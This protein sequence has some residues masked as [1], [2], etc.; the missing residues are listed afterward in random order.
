MNSLLSLGLAVFSSFFP[1]T[2]YQNQD[3]STTYSCGDLVWT[4]PAGVGDNGE[5]TG[6][7]SVTCNLQALSGGGFPELENFELAQ[8]KKQ[9]TQIHS[10]PTAG[11]DQGLPSQTYDFDM[12]LTFSGTEVDAHELET[13]AT[14]EKTHLVSQ[15]NTESITGSSYDQYLKEFNLTLDVKPTAAQTG[16]YTAVVSVSIDM[17]KPWFAPSSI[18]QTDVV[19][20]VQSTVTSQQATIVTEL[21]NNL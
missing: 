18:F 3:L 16:Y 9:A 12:N 1:Q 8:I 7:A 20:A 5:L 21:Q 6:V 2:H 14:D 19:N 15:M 17:S 11:T 10:G 4:T 13:L